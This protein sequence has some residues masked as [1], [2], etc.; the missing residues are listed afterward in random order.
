[1]DYHL[2][3]RKGAAILLLLVAFSLSLALL[4]G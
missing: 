2:P 4:L 1:M 3:D